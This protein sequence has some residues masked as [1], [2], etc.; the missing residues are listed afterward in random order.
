MTEL[1]PRP[2]TDTW[3]DVLPSVG[4]LAAKIAATSFVPK[5]LRGQPASVAAAILTGRELNLGPMAALRGLEVIDGSVTMKPEMMAARIL[6]AGHS[7]Q[8]VEA[9][10]KAC[11]VRIVRGDGL[12]EAESRFTLADA[13]RAGLAGK[14]NWQQWPGQM[15][16]ARALANAARMACPDVILGLDV[17][18]PGEAAT[19]PAGG[20]SRVALTTATPEPAEAAESPQEPAVAPDE[21]VAPE[22]PVELVTK[23]QLRKLN[24][25]VTQLE[26]LSGHALSKDERRIL[27]ARAGDADPNIESATKLTVGE[28]SAAIEWLDRMIADRMSGEDESPPVTGGQT[29]TDP[30]VDHGPDD[31]PVDAEVVDDNG[32][33]QS[34]LR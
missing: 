6:S 24:A 33:G 13:Q 32:D 21:P 16:R 29:G 27:I 23:A 9:S 19:A 28:A 31:E 25:Q 18:D 17:A 14:R 26:R 3:V 11:T 15:C 1:V 7:I 4:D 10:D 30:T 5:G 2:T 34:V 8:W 20:L 22:P 12:S